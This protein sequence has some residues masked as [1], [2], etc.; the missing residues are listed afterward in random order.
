MSNQPDFSLYAAVF[1]GLTL[2]GILY[3]SIVGWMST[4]KYSEGFT[5]LLVAAGVL[6][7]VCA[8]GFLIGWLAVGIVLL[9]FAF[10]GAPMVIG[11]VVRYVCRRAE[12]Q[13]ALRD[14]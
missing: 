9:G 1:F 7:T 12:A 6:V 11:S 13:R 5:S 4:H 3:N 14:E 8:C 2:F 10:S